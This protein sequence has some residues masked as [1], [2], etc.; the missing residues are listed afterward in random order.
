MELHHQRKSGE[1]G[2]KPTSLADVYGSVWI[3]GGAG[4]VILLWGEPGDPVVEFKHLKQPMEP[5]GPW[6][7]IH[8]HHAGTS[9]VDQDESRD[10]IWRAR[11]SPSG[12]TARTAAEALFGKGNPTQGEVERARRKREAY[13]RAGM[14]HCRPGVRGG[15]PGRGESSY[16]LVERSEAA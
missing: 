4:S 10:L 15:G 9:R 2:G 16:F 3:T 5:I 8:D 12:L 14:M 11:R 7:V 6:N 1:G 13:V